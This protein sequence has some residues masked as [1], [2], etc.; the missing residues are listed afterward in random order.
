MSSS[1]R[2]RER[3]G[4]YPGVYGMGIAGAYSDTNTE[5]HVVYRRVYIQVLSNPDASNWAKQYEVKYETNKH[6]H[7]TS[8]SKVQVKALKSEEK[9]RNDDELMLRRKD[10]DVHVEE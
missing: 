9:N 2:Y 3:I 10:S 5:G 1:R 4:N 6:G 8:Q 7:D